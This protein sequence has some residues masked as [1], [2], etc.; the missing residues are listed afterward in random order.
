MASNQGAYFDPFG[1]DGDW[2]EVY[3]AGDTAVDMAGLYFTDNLEE[4]ERWRIP[5]EAPEST[6]VPAGGYLVFFADGNPLAGPLHLDFKLSATG[7]EIGLGYRSGME[8]NWLDS[9]HFGAMTPNVSFGRLPDGDGAWITMN[10]YTPGEANVRTGMVGRTMAGSQL[11]LYPN[12]VSEGLHIAWQL[13]EA[14]HQGSAT[15][16][17]CDM[18]GR[19]VMEKTI[20]IQGRKY[21]GTIEVSML[22]EGIYLLYLDAGGHRKA[23]RIV[24]GGR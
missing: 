6:T 8:F 22:S 15:L 24:V 19:R 4:P 1:N 18:T 9:L 3:N 21:S 17:V 2:I 5:G 20:Q 14:V 16:L 11:L 10:H 13:P 7:E 23:G 12:P